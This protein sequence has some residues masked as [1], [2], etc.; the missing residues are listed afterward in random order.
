MTDSEKLTIRPHSHGQHDHPSPLERKT[1][2]LPQLKVGDI[3]IVRHKRKLMRH[4]LRKATGSH[5]DHVAMVIFPKDP[6]KGYSSHII[7]EAIQ[8]SFFVGLRRGTEVHKLEKYLLRPDIYEIGIKRLEGLD[9]GMRSRIRAYMLMNV[10][11]PYYHLWTGKFFFAW[12]IPSYHRYLIRFQRYSCSSLIQKAYYESFPW[13]KKPR[14]MFREK[15]DSPIE[16]QELITPGDIAESDVLTWI[17]NE[18]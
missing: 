15:G 16:L 4:F 13:E 10:D 12:L 7:V 2:R 6:P 8:D 1:G 11:S 3:I 14:V 18:K 17:Y 9:D 5:W